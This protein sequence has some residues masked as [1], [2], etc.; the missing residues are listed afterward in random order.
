MFTLDENSQ[1][2]WDLH[3]WAGIL[4]FNE[5]ELFIEL[6]EALCQ[7]TVKWYF[8]DVEFTNQMCA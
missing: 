7:E 8:Y 5:L 3:Q 6:A 1:D 2:F 4:G